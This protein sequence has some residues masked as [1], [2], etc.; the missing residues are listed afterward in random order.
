MVSLILVKVTFIFL[1][2]SLTGSLKVYGK[3]G[4][5]LLIVLGKPGNKS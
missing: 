4:N 5:K 1:W 3:E 2:Y